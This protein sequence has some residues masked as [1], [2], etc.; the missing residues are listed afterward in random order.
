MRHGTAL[1]EIIA[2]G[3]TS[4]FAKLVALSLLAALAEGL[5]FVLLVPLLA[6]LGEGGAPRPLPVPELGLG[7]LLAVFVLLVVLR[8]LIEVARRLAVQDL[9]LAVVD[10]LRLRAVEAILDARWQWSARLRGGEGEA[11]VISDIE[12]CGYGVEMIGGLARIGTALTGLGLAALAISPPAALAG[13]VLAILGLAG[14]WPLRR[15]ARRLGEELSARYEALHGT[16]GETLSGL[17]VIKSFGREGEQVARIEDALGSLR[18][19]E[20]DYVRNSAL[21]QAMLQV[22]GAVVAALAVWLALERMG[23]PLA[24]V[25]ALAALFVRALPLLGELL[26]SAQGWSHARPAIE[27]TLAVVA[28]AWA[29]AEPLGAGAA[30]R[31]AQ[32]LELVDVVFDHDRDRPALGGIDLAIEAGSFIALSG[33]SGAGKSTLADLCAGLIAADRGQLV[34]DG[35]VIDDSNRA[36]WRGRV[37]YI[38]QDPVLFAGS[39]RDNLLFV[40]PEASE[41]E[42]RRALEDAHAGFVEQLPGGLDC[43]LGKAG[44]ALSGGER[45]R[46]ALARGLLRHPAL[47]ILDEATSA[48]DEASESAIASALCGLAG[49]CTIIAIAHRGLLRD[50]AQRVVRIAGGRL[51]PA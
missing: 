12:R 28:S 16:L 49:R 11:L 9:R 21:A 30:P 33:P 22:C 51:P 3:S 14:F 23:L 18:G 2:A 24:S 46:I 39:V 7:A 19:T 44:R 32:S 38:Q 48:L 37:A 10:G 20:R 13:L 4:R 29:N 25:L 43:D 45:Q 47:L 50:S 42:L 17:R 35:T 15:R 6:T 31:L 8:A 34:V 40:R 26:S 1:G 27:R 36:N 41:G 5:G